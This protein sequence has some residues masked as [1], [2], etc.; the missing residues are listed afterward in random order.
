MPII[1]EVKEPCQH[2][3][4]PSVDAY[5]LGRMNRRLHSG[6]SHS[7]T[8]CGLGSSYPNGVEGPAGSWRSR[9]LLSRAIRRVEGDEATP[10]WRRCGVSE[11]LD[12]NK[13]GSVVTCA[14]CL[15]QKAPRG[16]SAVPFVRYCKPHDFPEDRGCPGYRQEPQVGDLWPG[17]SEADFGYPV[18]DHGTRIKEAP[19]ADA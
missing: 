16:R 14:V 18:S 4:M 9:R 8:V 6:L 2:P 7:H 1:L 12:P 3:G 19:N 5:Y 17:G 10:D 11:N 13:V 15:A